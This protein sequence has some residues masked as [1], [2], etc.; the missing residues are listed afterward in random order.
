MAEYVWELGIDW[1]LVPV[2][3]NSSYMPGAFYKI[4]P[5]QGPP[6]RPVVKNGDTISFRVLDLC[7]GQV[8]KID[9]FTI[10]PQLATGLTTQNPLGSLQPPFPPEPSTQSSH[11]FT[12][13]P[14]PCWLSEPVPVTAVPPSGAQL[15][16]VLNFFVQ[17]TGEPDGILRTFC[18]DPEMIVGST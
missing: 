15:R 7:K 3:A 6:Q 5:E 14:F 16:F 4:Q 18:H 1:E 9:S 10:N 13:G 11:Y 2:F 17:A 8:R 12:G